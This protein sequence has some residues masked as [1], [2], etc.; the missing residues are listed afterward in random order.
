MAIANLQEKL[1]FFTQQKSRISNQ[2]SNVQM[3]Q[4][5]ATK[6]I[7][8]KQQNFNQ[9]LSALYYDDEY[10]YGTDEYSEQYE[11]LLNE[12]TVGPIWIDGNEHEFE[13]ASINSWES[14][15]ELEKENLENQ[16]NEVQTYET[17]WQKLLSTNIKNDFSYGSVGGK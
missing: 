17:S 5:S 11:I 8:T 1:L 9:Q 16:L 13:M 6:Q 7:Q 15:L 3:N 2:L 4:L 12:H 10:G 14:Q